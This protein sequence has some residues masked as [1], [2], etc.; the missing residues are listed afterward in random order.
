MPDRVS[1]GRGD[2]KMNT[3]S[4]HW[5]VLHK[6]DDSDGGQG[7]ISSDLGTIETAEKSFARLCQPRTGGEKRESVIGDVTCKQSGGAQ[8]VS[9]SNLLS[10]TL[11]ENAYQAV[12]IQKQISGPVY[13]A[14]TRLLTPSEDPQHV[15]SRSG[16]GS[17]S[18]EASATISTLRSLVERRSSM[19]SPPN[20]RCPGRV[21]LLVF[22]RT[23]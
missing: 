2:Q 21:G 10:F 14:T 8:V 20:W 6:E 16:S 17:R 11:E 23:P 1:L 5:M 3:E 22:V 7:L 13:T 15:F 18:V 19:P 9:S 12:V 4:I